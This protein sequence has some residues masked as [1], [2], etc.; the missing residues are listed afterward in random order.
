MHSKSRLFTIA[1]ALTGSVLMT[2]LP[3]SAQRGGGHGGGAS[4]GGGHGGGM[5][6]G[7]GGGRA[8]GGSLAT[9]GMGSSAAIGGGNPGGGRSFSGGNWS[10]GRAVGGTWGGGRNFSGNFAGRPNG[11]VA[12]NRFVGG[13]FSNWRGNDGWRHGRHFRRGFGPG[14]GFAFGYGYPYGYYDDLY[15][16]SGDYYPA[17][18]DS[19]VDTAVIE[20]GDDSVSACAARY[21]SYD[22]ASRTYL[23]YDGQRHPCP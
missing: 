10:G 21:R 6:F 14:V 13:N 16:Y 18:D 15:A 2:T 1:L 5:S 22:P 9:S 3:A 11:A 12:T 23:G 4:F 8:M 7:G 17:Y 19:Y 20:G